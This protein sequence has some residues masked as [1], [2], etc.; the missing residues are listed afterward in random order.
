[1]SARRRTLKPKMKKNYSKSKLL[2]LII[3]VFALVSFCSCEKVNEKLKELNGT[4]W[5][6]GSFEGNLIEDPNYGGSYFVRGDK[7][8]ISFKE[9][10]EQDNGNS[11]VIYRADINLKNFG[12]YDPILNT[13]FSVF[14][15]EH[16][17]EYTYKGKDLTFIFRDLSGIVLYSENWTGKVEGDKMTLKNVF[18]KTVEFKKIL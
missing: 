6:S 15:E 1:M 2:L 14:G 13:I 17:A 18:G 9:I 16:S 12:L 8:T 4:I 5:E 11:Y 10:L 7:I 3:N